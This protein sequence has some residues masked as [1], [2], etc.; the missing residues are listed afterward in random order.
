MRHIDRFPR[1]CYDPLRQQACD[2]LTA[3][4]LVFRRRFQQQRSGWAE[5]VSGC[6]LP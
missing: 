4:C 6:L 3:G 5:H 2:L 1:R